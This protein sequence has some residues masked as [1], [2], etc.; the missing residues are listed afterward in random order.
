MSAIAT[1]GTR[2]RGRERIG[3]SFR[4]IQEAKGRLWRSL[5]APASVA[6][7]SRREFSAPCPNFSPPGGTVRIGNVP[8][9]RGKEGAP[10][11]LITPTIGVGIRKTGQKS[12]GMREQKQTKSAKRVARRLAGASKGQTADG[13]NARTPAVKQITLEPRRKCYSPTGMAPG[14]RSAGPN[15]TS[16]IWITRDGTAT[17]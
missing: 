13:T 1:F 3:R 10:V 7:G 6:D 4:R 2:R 15:C 17:R 8:L 5:L 9:D 16:R 14:V 12:H 11:C